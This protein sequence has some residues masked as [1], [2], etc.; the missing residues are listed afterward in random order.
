ML[1]CRHLVPFETAVPQHPARL[2]ETSPPGTRRRVLV[3]D[4]HPD[5]ADT[6]GML[7]D[8][9]GYSTS[10]AYDGLEAFRQTQQFE[11]ELVVIDLHMPLID[12]LSAARAIRACHRDR[13]PLLMALTA[14]G[15]PATRQAAFEAGFDLHF[16]KPLPQ[17]EF[18]QVMA[19][20][21]PLQTSGLAA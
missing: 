14:D 7:L 12:G 11:P 3:V 8:Q 15:L 20:V 13:P 17:G 1:E 21:L 10:V 16:V 4:D 6:L 9:L 19:E 18:E 2:S 5:T